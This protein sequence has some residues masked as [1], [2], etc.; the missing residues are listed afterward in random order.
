MLAL[1]R[2]LHVCRGWRHVARHTSRLFTV[3]TVSSFAGYAAHAPITADWVA[4][5]APHPNH[6]TFS[7]FGREND[8]W[9][10]YAAQHCLQLV[11][12]RLGEFTIATFTSPYN[13]LA[14]MRFA[15]LHLRELRVSILSDNT[16]TGPPVEFS[17][18]IPGLRVLEIGPYASLA[19]FRF[20][21]AQLTSLILRGELDDLPLDDPHAVMATLGQCIALERA[22][23]VLRPFPD[24]NWTP[25]APAVLPHLSYL[26]LVFEDAE[27][28]EIG[29]SPA[30][31]LTNLYLPALRELT[32]C[33]SQ[34]HV[35]FLPP[36]LIFL[37]RNGRALKFLEVLGTVLCTQDLDS[38]LEPA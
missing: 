13:A 26:Y 28:P 36:A 20:P 27:E 25:G 10:P 37:A 9:N 22:E 2:L 1:L 12:P 3:L 33:W 8:D 24:P 17:S 29:A 31:L 32:L 19:Q 18:M 21:W 11:A 5:S 34:I 7:L 30:P 15:F 35:T 14:R 6:L 38:V 4:R 23:L 16:W